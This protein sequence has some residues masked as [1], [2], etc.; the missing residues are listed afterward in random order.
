[1]NLIN[2][3]R[4]VS[5]KHVRLQKTQLVMAMAGIC[6]GVAAM[7]AID[8]AN[9]SV[10]CSFEDSI[11]HITGR[12]TL[13]I[14]GAESGFPEAMLERVQNV[15]GVEYAVP[16]I[17]ATASLSGG[18]QRAL[19]I[20][21]IDVLQD[22]QIRDYSIND[23]SA[24][25]PDPLLFLARR[26]SI[27]LTRTMAAQEGIDI[28]QQIEMQ[29][30][31]GL[32]TFQVRGLLNPAGPARVA[33][34]DIAVMDIY[35]AQMAFGK[36]GR[37][38]RIDVSL[39]PGENFDT[40]QERIR[41]V[42]PAGY[43]IDTPAARTRQVEVLLSRF[44]KSMGFISCMALF[45]G[46]YLIYNTV[47]IA[48]VQRRKEIGIL[49]ALGAGRAE[50]FRL[51]LTETLLIA[52]VAS[53]LGA[54]LGYIFARATVDLVAQSVTDM[55]LRTSV[56]ELAFSWRAVLGNGATGVLASLTA[57]ILPALAGTRLTPAS[58]I[59]SLPYSAESSLLGR[60]IKIASA[61]SLLAA[62]VIFAVFESAEPASAVRSLGVI[63]ASAIFL[64]LGIS[65][66]TPL[67]LRRIVPLCHG[68]LAACFGAQGRLAWLNLQK[69][70]SRN[71]VAVAAILCSI[72]L[73]VSSANAISSVRR[74]MFDW[75]DSIIRAD[76]LVS[77]GHPLATGGSPTI[78]MP[79]DM[80]QEME[81]VSGVLSVEPFR[82]G[83]LNYEGK[84]VLLEIFD[85]ARRLEYCPA[86]ITQGSRED[87]LRLPGRDN[88][89]VNEGFAVKHAIKP[90]NTIV[91]PTPAGPVP[92]GVTAIVVSYTSD[93]GAI[94]M[95]VTTYRRHWQ[96]QLVDTF[97]V[98][99]Q[100]GRDIAA[101]REAILARFGG[102]RRLFALPAAEFKV[103]VQKMLDRSFVLTNAVNILTLI[104]A[105]LGIII[106]LLASVLERTREIGIL[107]GIGMQKNQ[108][109]AV[110]IIESILLGAAGGAL[111]I[112]TGV[113][114][115]WIELEGVF[116][117]DF[118]ASITYHLHY[119]AMAWAMLL[120]AGLS[121]MAGLYP[122][123]RA[124]AT[125]I[126]EALTYE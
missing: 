20:L 116:R 45:V 115:G 123:Q 29:T 81:K 43:S 22:H 32:R 31:A 91:L 16:V 122:A 12:A 62:V 23:E 17:E 13:Q 119:G 94:W 75:I 111:G 2:L 27:L 42:L 38:D 63:M 18:R 105:G 86:M 57:A 97:E 33:G 117:L 56:T 21:G 106:T 121:A 90:G 96:D 109:S 3:L 10:L 48:V 104:I 46:M 5:F 77:T 47:S 102:E 26:D 52:A 7:V 100:P 99:V 78:P 41:Q 24:D 126:V 54:G 118:G 82:K 98:L 70:V 25:I 69:N 89:V 8:L 19:M 80:Q 66:C 114:I 1:M 76:I 58:A 51:F 53:L 6:L 30:V 87:M 36:E 112:A 59:R 65:L 103:E 35:A 61:L 49:R 71:G 39:L 14:T 108:V 101:V 50:I 84:K 79:G 67:L 11:N 37:I 125:N 95:D 28:D 93:S 55:Y 68:V 85:V 88:I 92:F 15:A 44:R 120:A 113:L 110:V 73:F 4:H 9:R 60:K 74:S 124:A 34:G 107:R 64:L 83:Y 40:M 72:A